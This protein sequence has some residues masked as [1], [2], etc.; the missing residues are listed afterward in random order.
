MAH[1][2]NNVKMGLEQWKKLSCQDVTWFPGHMN[3]GIRHMVGILNKVD[4]VIEVHDARVP[5]SGRNPRFANLIK[6]RPGVLLLNKAD[7]A[8]PE[9]NRMSMEYYRRQNQA[10]VCVSLD[11]DHRTVLDSLLPRAIAQ[12]KERA[13]DKYASAMERGGRLRIMVVGVPNVGKSTLINKLRQLNPMSG[14][15]GSPVKVGQK[16]GVTRGVHDDIKI[17]EAPDTRIV[18]TP[19]IMVP[20]TSDVSSSLKLAACNTMNQDI[21]GAES[22]TEYL[23]YHMN[24][25]GNLEYVKKYRLDKPADDLDEFLTTAA[26]RQGHLL[27][28][29]RLDKHRVAAQFI[30]RFTNG[31]LGQMV[32]DT[33]DDF[34]NLRLASEKL[35][36]EGAGHS[37]FD[38]EEDNAEVDYSRNGTLVGSGTS[39]YIA[40]DQK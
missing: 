14:R 9:G 4:Y 33:V 40:G 13:P 30:T 20:Y 25:L 15:S 29:G 17:F 23:L 26:K 24:K 18:D 28:G 21:I 32:L 34:D 39:K 11:N 10:A 5:V 1:F 31:D 37:I 22:L 16:P 27:K 6:Q 7:L 38:D 19:G 35:K 2:A 36:I 3:R 12:I 8:T